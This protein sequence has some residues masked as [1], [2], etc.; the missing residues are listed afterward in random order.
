MNKAERVL[1]G[2]MSKHRSQVVESL[3]GGPAVSSK[4]LRSFLQD[5][6][7]EAKTRLGKVD[8]D[9]LHDI[10]SANY[11]RNPSNI[12]ASR[13]A[14]R[15]TSESLQ[16]LKYYRAR[17]RD[18]EDPL[19]KGPGSILGRQEEKK[20]APSKVSGNRFLSKVR[21]HPYVSGGVGIGV[22]G[23]STYGVHR[24]RNSQKNNTENT[25]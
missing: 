9:T 11:F 22:L 3:K 16:D 14:N 24:Y 12:N 4:S 15:V 1:L 17:L 2:V 20:L 19:A 7:H 10:T 21:T 23:A 13:D 25:H 18:A 6:P 5:A 8:R